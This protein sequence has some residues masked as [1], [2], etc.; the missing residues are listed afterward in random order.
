MIAL[1][2]NVFAQYFIQDNPEQAKHASDL[3]ENQLTSLN[4]GFVSTVVLLELN[5]VLQNIY[6][7]NKIDIYKIFSKSFI[8]SNFSC[9][10]I[11]CSEIS[12]KV[13]APFV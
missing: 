1:D 11:R 7:A 6:R 9:R 13:R 5:W 10:S 2:T 12:F 8:S 3:L 4:Q